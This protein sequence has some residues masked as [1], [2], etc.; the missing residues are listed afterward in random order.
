MKKDQTV[1]LSEVYEPLYENIVIEFEALKETK[2][3]IQLSDNVSSKFEKEMNVVYK[4]VAVAKDVKE[5]KLGDWVLPSPDCIPKQI[6][7]IY[8]NTKSGKVQ[9]QIHISQILGIVDP[10]YALVANN[11]AL[12]S[13][14]N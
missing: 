13:V 6:P 2:S 8:R 4:V 14:V 5:I 10:E 7:L 9:A 3:G 12:K 11:S 1:N